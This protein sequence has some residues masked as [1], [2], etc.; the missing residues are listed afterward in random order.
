[1][2][3]ITVLAKEY[4]TTQVNRYETTRVDINAG[5]YAREIKSLIDDH[6]FHKRGLVW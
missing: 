1:M 2:T 6:I 4:K 3:F 5:V